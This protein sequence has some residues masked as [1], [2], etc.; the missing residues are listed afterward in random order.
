MLLSF[1]AIAPYSCLN[2]PR[3]AS[4]FVWKICYLLV[5]L[6]IVCLFICFGLFVCLFIHFSPEPV[7]ML[8]IGHRATACILT[9]AVSIISIAY[10]TSGVPF[11][12]FIEAL[13]PLYQ[14]PAIWGA[15]KFMV[16]FP[17][18]YHSFNGLRH[19]V[20]RLII[21]NGNEFHQ[22][23]ISMQKIIKRMQSFV[24]IS[25]SLSLCSIGILDEATPCSSLLELA[26]LCWLWQLSVLLDWSCTHLLHS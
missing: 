5:C 13:H 16:A 26:S 17:F 19:L 14:N 2:V 6:L 20:K 22:S 25:L 1:L 15:L 12:K 7:W 9:P 3:P 23:H 10:V 8:S 18:A 21:Y 24:L 4:Y 11:P